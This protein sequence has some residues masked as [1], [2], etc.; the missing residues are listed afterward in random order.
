VTTRRH[1]RCSSPDADMAAISARPGAQQ[2]KAPKNQGLLPSCRLERGTA[3]VRHPQRQNSISRIMIGMGMPMSQSSAPFPTPMVASVG[4]GIAL[5]TLQDLQ[6]ST[7]AGPLINRNENGHGQI[8]VA[9]RVACQGLVIVRAG[10]T[11]SSPPGHEA[12]DSSFRRSL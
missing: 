4:V 11:C 3:N 9:F 6:S 12:A 1:W 7:G 8:S 2:K 10:G 5:P